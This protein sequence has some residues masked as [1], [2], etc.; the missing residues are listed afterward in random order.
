MERTAVLFVLLSFCITSLALQ[1]KVVPGRLKQIDAGNGRV[2]GV[3]SKNKMYT[4]KW[5]RF[6][7]VSGSWKH[8]S[9]GPA[10]VW[11]VNTNNYIYKRVGVIWHKALVVLKQV[12]AGRKYIAGV[13]KNNEVYCLIGGK[14]PSWRKIPGK[15]K[16]YSCGPYSCWGV[17][18]TDSIFIVKGVTPTACGGSL[19]QIPGSLS[20]IDVSTDGKVYGVNSNGDIYQRE[21]VSPSNPA[22]TKW[23]HI[24]FA[25]KFKHISYDRGHLWLISRDDSIRDCTQ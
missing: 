19:Q 7:R 4:L 8:V 11:G 10:G 22:G 3:N 9:V 15:L 17:N 5:N 12:D 23:I 13:R 24:K 20:M 16:Y 14:S 21:G 1:C 6:L 25:M 18:S 2:F